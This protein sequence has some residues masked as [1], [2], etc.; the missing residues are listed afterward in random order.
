MILISIY[1]LSCS[2]AQH[3]TSRISYDLTEQSAFVIMRASLF[4]CFCNL[5]CNFP[6]QS[7]NSHSTAALVIDLCSFFFS[8]ER[9]SFIQHTKSSDLRYD[10]GYLGLIFNVYAQQFCGSFLLYKLLRI[11]VYQIHAKFHVFR[12][13]GVFFQ[14][15]V[16]NNIFRSCLLVHCFYLAL[17]FRFSGAGTPT[18]Y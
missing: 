17:Q 3:R 15:Q 4:W 5:I 9:S 14:I 10:L 6:T 13:N 11:Q 18:S 8:T 2:V 7:Y 12:W 1:Q 16:S